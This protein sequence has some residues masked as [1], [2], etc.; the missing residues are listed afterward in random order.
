MTKKILIV[1]DERELSLILAEMLRDDGYEV[2]T[3]SNAFKALALIEST[4]FALMFLDVMMPIMNG[5]ELLKKF[6]LLPK[7]KNIPVVLM[8][9]AAE[10]AHISAIANQIAKQ[11]DW[12]EFLAKPFTLEEVL[13][14][15]QKYIGRSAPAESPSQ[16][17]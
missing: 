3:A 17:N 14:L 6:R 15:T 12:Q 11:V 4:E 1:D 7:C 16:R 9:A 10:P 5:L 13:Q 2:S 8:S